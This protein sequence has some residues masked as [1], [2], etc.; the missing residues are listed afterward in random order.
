M[1]VLTRV[2]ALRVQEAHG[3]RPACGTDLIL[4]KQ[5]EASLNLVILLN[6][7]YNEKILLLRSNL[8]AKAHF[9]SPWY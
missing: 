1:V 7:F 8:L 9:L 5:T 2:P 6:I 3:C 4:L